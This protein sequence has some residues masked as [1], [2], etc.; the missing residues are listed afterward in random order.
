MAVPDGVAGVPAAGV[1]DAAV[2]AV[3]GAHLAFQHGLD[4]RTHAGS[5]WKHLATELLPAGSE[6]HASLEVILERG[7]LARRI[8]KAFASSP[9]DAVYRELCD[10]LTAGRMFRAA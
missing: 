8:L 6:W 7:T 5:V 3:A 2:A 4:A 10:C 9:L 1:P